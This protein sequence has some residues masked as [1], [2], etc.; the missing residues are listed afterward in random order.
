MARR[1]RQAVLP[2]FKIDE[3]TTPHSPFDAAGSAAGWRC[4]PDPFGG[5]ACALT[6]AQR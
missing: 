1:G 3:L 6:D 2:D 4:L 5:A